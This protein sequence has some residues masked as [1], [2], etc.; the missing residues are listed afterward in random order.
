MTDNDILEILKKSAPKTCDLDPLP[1]SLLFECLDIVLPFLTQMINDSLLSGV[2]PDVHKQ[3]I[4]KPLLKKPS[5][6]PN[7]FKNFRP[8]S[9]LSFVSKLIEKVVLSQLSDHLLSNNLFS[10]YQSAYRPGHS[11]ETALMKIVNDLLLTL[12]EGKLAV[13]TLL[14]LSAA[15]DTI[16]HNILLSRLEHVFGVSDTALNWFTSYL[17]KRIQTVSVGNN[18]SDPALITFGVPQGSV[19]GPVLFVLYTAP[20]SEIMSTHSVL[21]HSFADDTQLHKSAKPSHVGELVESM[22]ACIQDIKSWMTCNKLK[23]NDDKTEALIISSPRTSL[24]ALLPDALTVGDASVPFS[25]SARNLGVVLDCH[26][27]MNAQVA[28]VIRTVNFELRRISS[29]RH[30]LSVEATKT[31]IS[32]FVFSRL[33]Y[34]NGLLVNC[35]QD[36]LQRFQKIQNTAARLV[37]KVPRRDHITPHLRTLHWLPIDARITYKVACMCFRAIN[38]TGPVYL[39]DLLHTYTPSRTLRSSSDTLT[40][41]KPRISTKTFGERSFYSA[42]PAIWNSLPFSIRSSPSDSAFRSSLKTH[43]FKQ[44]LS[45]NLP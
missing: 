24:S 33:D 17:S 14:D 2:F 30:F 15:F 4:V 36:L 10:K 19:L 25:K 23:L 31:L 27:T 41:I 38:G 26:L 9:N 8:V 12:D 35:P 42:A 22:E 7:D 18:K 37:L 20:L 3:A 34:C 13:L 21:F 43:L 6:D 5:L 29:I 40:L 11:T 44:S 39:S 28:N 16:D 32:A 45:V 1:T